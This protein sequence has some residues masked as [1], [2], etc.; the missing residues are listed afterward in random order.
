[1]SA[2]CPYCSPELDEHRVEHR[3]EDSNDLCLFLA[4]RTPFSLVPGS[5]FRVPTGETSS[6]SPPK[7]WAATFEL[8]ATVGTSI[9]RE[10]APAGY[11]VGWNS[12]VTAG[13]EVFHSHMHVIPRFTDEPLAGKG[14]RYWLKQEANRRTPV[15]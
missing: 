4:S 2:T 6:T 9:D 13:Q 8:L 5:S 1:V 11:N 12:G 10:F 3:V 7:E 15:A 14:I